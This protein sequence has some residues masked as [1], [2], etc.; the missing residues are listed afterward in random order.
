MANFATTTLVTSF[1]GISSELP[2]WPH[3]L[4]QWMQA[5]LLCSVGFAAGGGDELAGMPGSYVLYSAVGIV[6][7]VRYG[8]QP[9]DNSV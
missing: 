9:Q 6:F 2:C 1:S 4:V 5:A 7:L 3:A 8:E